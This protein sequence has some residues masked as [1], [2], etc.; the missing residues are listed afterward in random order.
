MD[1]RALGQEAFTAALPPPRQAGASALCAH[2][3]A[4]SVL[5]FS[6]ALGAL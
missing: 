1:F 3:R 5:I 6:G 2:A 4:K